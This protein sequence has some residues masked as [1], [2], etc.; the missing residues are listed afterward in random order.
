L[1][2]QRG[3]ESVAV[4][5]TVGI[6]RLGVRGKSLFFD[7]KRFVLRGRQEC[8]MQNE[9]CR[10]FLECH[11]DFLRDTWTVLVVAN[12]DDEVCEF[13]SRRGILLVADLAEEGDS[14]LDLLRRVS[15][16]PA[17]GF[18][19]LAR[20]ADIS[21]SQI[22]EIPNLLLAQFVPVDQKLATVRWADLLF[23][24]ISQPEILANKI[25]GI[26]IPVVAVRRLANVDNIEQARAECDILQS[27]LAP[28]G[29]F[30]GFVV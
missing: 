13:A 2:L 27:D 10:I 1:Q 23:I 28:F 18:A 25:A 6:R 20:G 4:D 15:R 17:V 14:P 12:P 29:D 9:E 21:D 24:E 7:G 26:D 16:W 11:Q 22:A 19:I 3:G 8:R 30:A 5:R